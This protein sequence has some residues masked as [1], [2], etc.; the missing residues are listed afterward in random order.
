MERLRSVFRRRA[1]GSGDSWGWYVWNEGWLGSPSPRR[2]HKQGQP[3]LMLLPA[4]SQCVSIVNFWWSSESQVCELWKA[5]CSP[6]PSSTHCSLGLGPS[7]SPPRFEVNCCGR[8]CSGWRHRREAL[9]SH[10]LLCSSRRHPGWPR[11]CRPTPP[12][13]ASR[14]CSWKSWV[15]LRCW[16][17]RP[18]HRSWSRTAGWVQALGRRGGQSWFFLVPTSASSSMKQAATPVLSVLWGCGED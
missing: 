18:A 7:L 13:S 3:C 15:H 17:S 6:P 5:V 12:S 1:M 16:R 9:H 10:L 4:G 14:T 8:E 11:L 2:L